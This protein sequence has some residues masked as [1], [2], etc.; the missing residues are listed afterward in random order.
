MS[1]PGAVAKIA[2]AT[3]VVAINQKATLASSRISGL[4]QTDNVV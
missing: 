3:A 2:W 1:M 4:A